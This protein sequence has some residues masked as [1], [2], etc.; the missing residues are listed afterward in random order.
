[1][2]AEPALVDLK[3]L[4]ANRVLGALDASAL[5]ELVGL[6]RINH[7]E[8]GA[9]IFEK[10]SPGD[11]LY[12]LL[13][14]RVGIRTMSPDG[15]EVFLNILEAGAIFGEIAML[16]GNQRTAGASVMDEAELLRVD[17]ADF[18]PFLERHPKLCIR[19]MELLAQRVRWTSDIIESTIFLDIPRRLAKRL[20]ALSE[21]YGRQQDDGL[22]LDIKLYT[23]D[24]AEMLGATRESASKALHTLEDLGAIR[25]RRGSTMILDATILEQVVSGD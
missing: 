10:G 7:F 25:Y 5:T 11:C 2:S 16:D 19:L 21:E 24:L 8:T 22:K 4:A 14:G 15:Q 18:M 12:V 6:G 13:S 23:G 1:M 9:T 3:L 17:R 20:L